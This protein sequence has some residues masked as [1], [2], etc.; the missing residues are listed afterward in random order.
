MIVAQAEDAGRFGLHRFITCR[1]DPELTS[2]KFLLYCFLTDD[3][4]EKVGEASPGG[5]GR[6]R[7]LGIEKL[8]AIQVPIPSPATQRTFDTLQTMV[9]ELKAR[10]ATI[11]QNNDALRPSTLERVFFGGE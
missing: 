1:G 4:L 2:P 6:N 5:A 8:I 11:R 9:A 7:T 10:H 3:G